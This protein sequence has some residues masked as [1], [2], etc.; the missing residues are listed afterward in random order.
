MQRT[1]TDAVS[2]AAGSSLPAAARPAADLAR[3]ALRSMFISKL[4]M[5]VACVVLIGLGTWMASAAFAPVNPVDPTAPPA[6]AKAIG[7]PKTYGPIEIRLIANQTRYEVNLDGA[8]PKAFRAF[9]ENPEREKPD[10]PA[11]DAVLEIKNIS[12]KRVRFW[13]G[14]DMVSID[15]Q[16]TGPD[17]VAVPSRRPFTAEFRGTVINALEPGQ[18]HRYELRR[19]GSGMRGLTHFSYWLSPGDYKLSAVLNT[20]LLP[21]LEGSELDNGFGKCALTTEP[22]TL[23]VVA[24]R[25]GVLKQPPQL[26]QENDNNGRGGQGG[27]F[28]PKAPPVVQPQGVPK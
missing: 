3:G 4:K 11:L 23:N 6:P 5:T 1:S 17:A 2:F 9:L 28:V 26:P 16:L 7:K 8:T 10:P 19:L 14:G 27:G 21:A 24:G 18:T 20:A 25:G 13:M 22:I 15:F 12:D